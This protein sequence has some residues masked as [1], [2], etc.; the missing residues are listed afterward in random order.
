M[1]AQ[2]LHCHYY[3]KRPSYCCS[4][5]SI[6]NSRPNRCSHMP[7]YRAKIPLRVAFRWG[8]VVSSVSSYQAEGRPAGLFCSQKNHMS[9][10]RDPIQPPQN[11][12]CAV[13]LGSALSCFENQ[14]PIHSRLAS[15][16]TTP[17]N[18]FTPGSTF[19][20]SKGFVLR[21]RDLIATACGPGNR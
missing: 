17:Q 10:F 4:D 8:M 1:T 11:L 14:I 12:N 6:P 18:W 3:A 9:R 5:C 19:L 20:L 13:F 2:V 15:G 16:L 7:I 21:E